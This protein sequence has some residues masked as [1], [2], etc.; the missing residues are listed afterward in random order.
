[1]ESYK[2]ANIIPIVI[3]EKQTMLI[4]RTVPPKLEACLQSFPSF[5]EIS[6]DYETS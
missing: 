1:V 6:P 5:E 4:L 3:E 2:E